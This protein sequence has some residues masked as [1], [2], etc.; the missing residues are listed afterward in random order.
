MLSVL[1]IRTS[2]TAA[3]IPKEALAC[4]V[5]L[6][7]LQNIVLLANAVQI[8]NKIVDYITKFIDKLSVIDRGL[9]SEGRCN[10]AEGFEP[11]FRAKDS[12]FTAPFWFFT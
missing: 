9:E 7:V 4:K 1:R 3:D 6:I 5:L 11:S 8:R 10:G 12:A 2:L